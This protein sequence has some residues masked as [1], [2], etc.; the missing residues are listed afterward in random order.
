VSR[1]SAFWAQKLAVTVA[2]GEQ[3]ARAPGE[4]GDKVHVSG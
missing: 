3:L 4:G 1:T 2:T